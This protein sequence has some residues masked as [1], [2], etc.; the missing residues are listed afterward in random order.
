MMKEILGNRHIVV[1]RELTQI[2]EE[3]IR[4]DLN[5][6]LSSFEE[7]VSGIKGEVTLIV[8]GYQAPPITNIHQA[9]REC[10]DKFSSEKGL[11]KRDLV[12]RIARELD[13]SRKIVYDTVHQTVADTEE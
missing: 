6:V 3:F 11:S 9:I 13:L 4:G 7:R 5:D 1:A 2:H 10:Y 12:D 8:T